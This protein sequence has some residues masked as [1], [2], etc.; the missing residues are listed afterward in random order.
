MSTWTPASR[1]EVELLLSV[2]T[3]RLNRIHQSRLEA[4]LV[5]LRAVPVLDSLCESV[6]VVAEH[7]GGVI[8]WSDVE[9]GWEYGAL[10]QNGGI[11]CRGCNQ[12]ELSHVIHQ[13]FDA[14]ESR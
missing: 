12:F 5:P 7:D 9:D 11:D 10:N 4:I 14:P 8:Y 6:Y 1:E 2:A 3:S 13:L